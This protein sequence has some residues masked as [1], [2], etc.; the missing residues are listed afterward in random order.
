VG[1]RLFQPI[2]MY[3]LSLSS[4]P[5]VCQCQ[6]SPASFTTRK[7]NLW[8]ASATELMIHQF[9]GTMPSCIA[10]GKNETKRG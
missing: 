3:G 2:Q 6:S 8:R 9:Q 7:P 4:P 5:G 1:C 10:N